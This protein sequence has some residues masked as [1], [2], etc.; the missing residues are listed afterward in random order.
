MLY[1]DSYFSSPYLYDDLTEQKLNFCSTVRQNHKWMPDNCRSKT[2]KLKWR[3]SRTVGSG[4]VVTW[5]Q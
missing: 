5:Q 3:D 2:L 1:I 4:Q